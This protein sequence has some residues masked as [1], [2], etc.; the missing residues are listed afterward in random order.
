MNCRT[1]HVLACL[2]VGF[3]ARLAAADDLDPLLRDAAAHRLAGHLH[4]TLDMLET[5]CRA[6]GPHCSPQVAGELGIAY[7]QAHRFQEAE[8]KL[9]DAYRRSTD[10]KEKARFANDLGNLNASRGR[11]DAARQFFMEARNATGAEP[12]VRTSAG[13]N[14]VRLTPASERLASLAHLFDEI[15][16]IPELDQRAGFFLNLG[17]QARALGDVALKLAYSS[18]D[19]ARALAP[20]SGDRFLLAEV[21]NELAQ[22]YEDHARN[23]DALTLTDEAVG[24]VPSGEREGGDLLIDLQWRRGRLLRL[25]GDDERAVKAYELA[26]QQIEAIRQDI[27][28]EYSDG[29][30]SFRDTLEPVYQ[31]LADLLLREAAAHSG[32]E[33][34]RLFRRARDTVELIKQTELQDYLGERCAV[35][36]ARPSAGSNLPS[37]TAVLYPVILPDR[38]ELIVE[39]SAGIESHQVRI[40]ATT[41]R[42]KAQGFA[43]SLRETRIDY[44]G[45]AK[46]LYELLLR[47][48]EGVLAQNKIETL[49]VVPDGALRLIPFGALYDGKHF[50]I[51]E[52][53]I[54][55]A[56]GLTITGAT[57]QHAQG[58]VLLA[59]VSEPGPAVEKLPKPVLDEFLFDDDPTET[60]S[61]ELRRK[62]ALAGVKQEIQT[63]QT[64]VRGDALLNED[65]TVDR[66][67]RQVLTGDYRVLHIASHAM[68][69][70]RSANSFIM[71]YDDIL[72]LDEFQ[73]LLRTEPLQANPIDM[74][75]LSACQTADGDDRA[76]LGFAGAALKAHANSA[77]GSLWRVGDEAASLLMVR[78]YELLSTGKL[79]KAKALQQAQMQLSQNPSF[80]HPYYWAPFILVGGW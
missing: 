15:E 2:L 12:G 20:S 58:R 37:R 61:A 4:T 5:A 21:L 39:T 18:L 8:D 24:A 71:A 47:P 78:F 41:M 77:V 43:R 31:G 79:S 60:R 72:T 53:A 67:R 23:K 19:R 50:A 55:T 65:F 40:D 73:R 62:L 29:R 9:Q 63:L 25:Q 3:N 14:L 45:W 75:A 54:V 42:E 36:S 52:H 28:V 64:K 26:V 30:S 6:P 76:P 80:Q 1:L 38:L 44:L 17:S 7:Y 33:R 32:E 11:I 57:P 70:K 74:I 51:E 68:F 69:S 34:Q 10:A 48:L 16:L 59:G 35:E 56:P 66:F 49:V 22:L 13:L 27:P 46:H